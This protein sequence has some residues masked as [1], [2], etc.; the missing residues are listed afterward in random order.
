MTDAGILTPR[1][2]ARRS[3]PAAFNEAA[4]ANNSGN[5]NAAESLAEVFSR[6]ALTSPI[7]VGE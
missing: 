5:Y 7:R 1:Q 6:R 2:P 4:A 3:R